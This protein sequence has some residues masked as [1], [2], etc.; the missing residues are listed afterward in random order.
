MLKCAEIFQSDSYFIIRDK[1]KKDDNSI[2][3]LL[4]KRSIGFL[5]LVG[6]EL[7]GKNNPDLKTLLNSSFDILTNGTR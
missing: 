1:T 4:K 3:T 7:K 2:G 5:D 6:I